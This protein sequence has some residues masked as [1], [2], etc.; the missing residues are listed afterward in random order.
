MTSGSFA[1][2]KWYIDCLDEEG[3]LVILYWA[4]LEWRRLR[5]T[6]QSVVR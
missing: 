3:R 4:S 1:F 5:F 6:W 2:T